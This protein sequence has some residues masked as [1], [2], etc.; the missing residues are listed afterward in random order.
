LVLLFIW[1]GAEVCGFACSPAD[2]IRGRLTMSSPVSSCLSFLVL[3][4]VSLYHTVL[5]SIIMS[6]FFSSSFVCMKLLLPLPSSHG[7]SLNSSSLWFRG[8]SLRAESIDPRASINFVDCCSFLFLSSIVLQVLGAIHEVRPVLVQYSSILQ[9]R[10]IVYC[11][12]LLQL[13]GL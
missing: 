1:K 13:L 3:F 7:S 8:Y 12:L 11:W 6:V 10:A 2:G 5:D 4:S 9:R